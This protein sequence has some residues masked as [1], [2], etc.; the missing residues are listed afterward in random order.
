[1]ENW[2]NSHSCNEICRK[3]GLVEGEEGIDE[4]LEEAADDDDLFGL[5]VEEGASVVVVA[6][7]LLQ[8][9]W[10]L[11]NQSLSSENFVVQWSEKVK[12]AQSFWEKLTRS[13][14]F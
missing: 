9:I 3:L 7:S 6:S 14:S 8:R 13:K 2:I 12:L 4:E 1:M 5:I 10:K 11:V